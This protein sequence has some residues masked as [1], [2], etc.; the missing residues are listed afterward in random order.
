MTIADVISALF[1]VGVIYFTAVALRNWV[2]SKKKDD[3]VIEVDDETMQ[4]VTVEI[5]EQSGKTYWL[6]HDFHNK[7]FIA[8]GCNEEEA[9]KNTLERIPGKKIFNVVENT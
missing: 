9:L 2:Q 6:V 3:D 4:L 8:Q 5:V 7:E 1:N